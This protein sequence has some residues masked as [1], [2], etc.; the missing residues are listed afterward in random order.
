MCRVL[1]RWFQV[2]QKNWT[3]PTPNTLPPAGLGHIVDAASTAHTRWDKPTAI[4][5]CTYLCCADIPTPTY[6][7]CTQKP[8]QHKHT[9]RLIILYVFRWFKFRGLS[10]CLWF[11]FFFFNVFLALL[12]ISVSNRGQP[13]PSTWSDWSISSIFYCGNKTLQ[14]YSNIHILPCKS[15]K[16]AIHLKTL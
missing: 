12:C 1:C 7:A 11:F 8:E 10:F 4:Y 2:T 13:K 9:H 16:W 3:Y 5:I 6:W 15:A 14:Y